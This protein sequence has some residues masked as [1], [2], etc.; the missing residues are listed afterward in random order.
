[1]F[2][3]DELEKSQ[4]QRITIAGMTRQDIVTIKGVKINGKRKMRAVYDVK[5][6]E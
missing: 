6:I 4:K 3:I 2:D 5:P 1:M